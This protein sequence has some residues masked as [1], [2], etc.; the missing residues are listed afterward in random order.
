MADS[1]ASPASLP[2]KRSAPHGWRYLLLA[3]LTEL[4][5][6]RSWGA[7]V[8]AVG[9]VHLAFFLVCQVVYS[10]GVRAS[11]PSLLLWSLEIAAVL[12]AI[13]FVAGPRWLHDSPTI[14]LIVRIWA[15]FLIL[16]FNIATL[17]TLTGW[18]LDWFKPV[19]CTLASFGFATMAWLFGYRFL[20]PAF[21]MYFTGLLMVQFPEWNY[22]IHGASWCAAL[23]WIGWD[24]TQRRARLLAVRDTIS[25]GA[26]SAVEATSAGMSVEVGV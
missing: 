9:W 2:Q 18:T 20:F 5:L 7:A 12:G 24:M 13:R 17:N 23:Q 8:M 6:R 11:G 4:A 22:L 15:T 25:S 19:W 10:V 26:G 14:T 21:Q 1:T 3:D 16:S